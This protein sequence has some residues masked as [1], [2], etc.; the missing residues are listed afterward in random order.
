MPV[1]YLRALIHL[2]PCW[3]RIFEV[4]L[5]IVKGSLDLFP[6]HRIRTFHAFHRR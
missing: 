5:E 6:V 3:R 4:Q 1:V 2:T